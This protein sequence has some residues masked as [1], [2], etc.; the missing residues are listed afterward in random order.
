MAQLRIA[1]LVAALASTVALI[2]CVVKDEP[3]PPSDV[4]IHV[5]PDKDPPDVI[6]T[7]PTTSTTTTTSGGVTG[8]QSNT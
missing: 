7:P 8:G 5:Q 3:E 6:V 2:G 4:D 1:H